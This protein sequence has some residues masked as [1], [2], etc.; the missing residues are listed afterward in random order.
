MGRTPGRFPVL[1][2]ERLVGYA[3]IIVEDLIG[4]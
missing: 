3:E 2:S 1:D 4:H